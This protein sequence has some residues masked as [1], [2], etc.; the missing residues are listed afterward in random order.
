M[1]HIT[2]IIDITNKCNM[3]CKYCY[4]GSA[5]EDFSSIKKINETF[6]LKIPLFFKFTDQI[7]SYNEFGH[8][9]FLFHGGEPLLINLENWK[10]VLNYFKE[11]NY[12]IKVDIQTNGT[13]INEDFIK[14]FKESDVKIGVSL[15]GPE[16]MND[17]NRIFKYGKGS[18]LII[19]RNLQKMKKEGLSF[20]CLVTLNK[21]N[22]DAKAIYSFFKKY[23]IPFNIRPIF[24]TKYS[25][26]KE[27]LIT[28]QE[29]AKSFCELFDLWFYDKSQPPLIGDFN[30]MVAR[31]INIKHVERLTTCTFIKDCSKSFIDYD[32]EGNLWPCNCLTDPNFYYGNIQKDSVANSLNTLKVKRLSTRWEKLSSLDCKNCEFSHYCYGGCPSRAYDYYGSYFKRDPFCASYKIIL[33]HIYTRIKSSLK[34]ENEMDKKTDKRTERN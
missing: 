16:S 34:N 12:P 9:N 28:P 29:Y 6:K 8:T 5:L 10:S 2:P 33:K 11:K 21:T 25:V 3:A 13:L 14:F 23:S 20:G 15:D 31:F 22:I 4:A 26:P 19:F 7:M 18:F 17:Q 24:D 30:N 1:N 27:L 32:T